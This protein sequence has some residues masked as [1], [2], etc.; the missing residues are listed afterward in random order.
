[1][2]VRTK[3]WV[4]SVTF[5][6]GLAS[7]L[8]LAESQGGF[9]VPRYTIDSGGGTSSSGDYSITGTVGQPE[10]D[11]DSASGGSYQV[12]GGFWGRGDSGYLFSD[13]FEN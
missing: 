9:D 2:R 11:A 8:A 3:V 10:A 5:I 13:G 12:S 6:V 4:V 1:M 7:G